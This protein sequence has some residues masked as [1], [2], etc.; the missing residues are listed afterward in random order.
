MTLLDDSLKA[1][2]F[3]FGGVLFDI[4][5]AAPVRAFSALGAGDFGAVFSQAAQWEELDRMDTGSIGEE[6]FLSFLNRFTPQANRA[7]VL[8]AWNSILIGLWPDRVEVVRKIRSSGRRTFLLSNTNALHVQAFEPMVDRAMGL[9]SLRS[10]FDA[11]YYSNV[12]RM[13]KP[14]PAVFL[15]V[16]EWNG[17]D[18]ASTLFVDDSIQHVEGAR[19]SGLRAF[20]L[21]P[22]ADFAVLFTP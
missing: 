22:G 14:D 16:C 13:R 6:E 11:V 21:Q 7:Q 12:I 17:L 20:H 4:D 19:R 8:E 15:R 18:P 5:Y 3:D 9:S 10:A 2:I 1:V